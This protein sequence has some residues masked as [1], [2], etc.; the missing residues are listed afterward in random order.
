MQMIR[1]SKQIR[2]ERMNKKKESKAA[3][4]KNIYKKRHSVCRER[5]K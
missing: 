3:S 1:L 5:V 4:E 2:S